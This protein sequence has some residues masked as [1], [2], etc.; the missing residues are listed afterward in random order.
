VTG[1]DMSAAI[2]ARDESDGSADI[3]GLTSG[4]PTDRAVAELVAHVA[5]TRDETSAR[6]VYRAGFA[7]LREELVLH[8][9]AALR[10]S[11]VFEVAA[12]T[13]RRL[14]ASNLPLGLAVTMH[15]YPLCALQCVP[16]P[17]LSPARLRRAF[18]LRAIRSRSLIVANAGSERTAGDHAPVAVVPDG[19]GVRVD[20]TYEYMSLSSIADVVFFK[21][22]L[23]GTDSAVLCAAD[24]TGDSVRIGR[25]KFRGSMR[26]SDTSAVT[27]VGHRIPADQCV[28]VP[29]GAA[30]RCVSD[31]QRCWFHLFLAEIHVARLER[32]HGLWCLARTAE[33]VAARNEMARLREYSLRLLD[34]PSSR[35][36]SEALAKTTA[37]MKLRASLMSQATVAALRER[38]SSV[39]DA[40]LLRTHAN[41]LGYIRSQP[42]ADEKI[43][44]S[45]ERVGP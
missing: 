44:R 14:A 9:P 32:L 34:E 3:G 42:T 6:A 28:V 25:W 39:A 4:L 23:A 16:I 45:L 26:L 35:G 10:A 33:H 19:D 20:G 31:Y 27:F 15:L 7:R 43:L 21:A 38:E 36:S 29:N 18:L 41:E 5:R 2:E 13:V 24:L 37:A 40:G 11:D 17:L 30:L 22:P 8:P 1:V 12:R